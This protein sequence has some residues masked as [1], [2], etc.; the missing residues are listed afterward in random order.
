MSSCR[1]DRLTVQ[2]NHCPIRKSTNILYKKGRYSLNSSQQS[3]SL[4]SIISSQLQLSQ[5][6]PFNRHPNRTLHTSGTVI[7]RNAPRNRTPS[8]DFTRPFCRR[9]R[10]RLSKSTCCCCDSGC[11]HFSEQPWRPKSGLLECSSLLLSEFD[12]IK[13][14][15]YRGVGTW[16]CDVNQNCLSSSQAS[17]VGCS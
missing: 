4:L 3:S 10:Q 15:N 14:G 13:Y 17:L 6:V 2:E 11:I 1:Y 12:S 9:S 16:R 8:I 5:A 7:P